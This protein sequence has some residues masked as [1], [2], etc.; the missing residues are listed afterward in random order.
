MALYTPKRVVLN[1]YRFDVTFSA[2]LIQSFVDGIERQ[3]TESV[4]KY[5]QGKQL[6]SH[7]GENPATVHQGLDEET[8][9]L[10]G[11]FREYFPSL[12]RRSAL[13]TLCGYFEHELDKLCLLY[14]SEKSFGLGPSDLSGKGIYRSTRYLQR[15]A[16]LN[17]HDQSQAWNDIM[18]IQTVRNV[19]A[20]KGGRL[21]DPPDRAVADFMKKI[22]SLSRDDDGEIAL[23][24]GF[25]SYV[26]QTYMNYFKLIGDSINASECA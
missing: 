1:W 5:E 2:E 26:V 8:W 16:G 21:P 13:L 12:Q 24:A 17:I 18:K 25:L 4:V 15:V 3:V 20:H 9:D 19:I 14:Q 6:S 10:T 23:G 11:I 7:P 22:T